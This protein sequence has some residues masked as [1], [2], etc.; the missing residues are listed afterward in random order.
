MGLFPALFPPFCWD[1][2]VSVNENANSRVFVAEKYMK[3]H[4]L[5]KEVRCFT[6]FSHHAE[7][8]N[9]KGECAYSHK[10]NLDM[11]ASS[12]ATNN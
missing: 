10:K 3:I 4:K 8:R 5:T 2:K 1:L 12:Y 9:N 6:F 7:L 11:D